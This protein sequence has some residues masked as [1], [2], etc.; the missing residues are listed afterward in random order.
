M[1]NEPMSNLEFFEMSKNGKIT[2]SKEKIKWVFTRNYTIIGLI[3]FIIYKLT[4]EIISREYMKMF[5]YFQRT[6]HNVESFMENLYNEFYILLIICIAIILSNFLVVLLSSASIFLKYQIKKSDLKNVIKRIV[7][8]QLIFI[9]VLSFE[10]TVAYINDMSTSDVNTRRL[11]QVIAGTFN[12]DE[13]QARLQNSDIK[14]IDE[15]INK[16]E[17][18]YTIRYITL[19]VTNIVCSLLCIKWQKKILEKNSV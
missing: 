15:N 8:I 18:I 2:T 12:V 6:M 11:G 19:L 17:I 16:M 4:F 7:T 10:F 13:I 14:L 9:G 1:E 3:F 5:N